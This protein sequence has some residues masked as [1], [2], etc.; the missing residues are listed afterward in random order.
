[1]QYSSTATEQ[2]KGMIPVRL[3]TET[4]L[5]LNGNITGRMYIFRNNGDTIWVDKRDAPYMK[6]LP[7][8]EVPL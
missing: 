2:Q 3:L 6:E 1:M 5:S 4:P 7:A 8:L